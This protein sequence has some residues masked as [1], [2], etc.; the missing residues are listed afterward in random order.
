MYAPTPVLN[1]NLFIRLCKMQEQPAVGKKFTTHFRRMLIVPKNADQ[2]EVRCVP[3]TAFCVRDADVRR[4]PAAISPVFASLFRRL[5]WHRSAGSTEADGFEITR[6]GV[7]WAE[8]H[9]TR[10]FLPS[11]RAHRH[12]P[13]LPPGI[14]S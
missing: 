12:L 1:F 3:W 11:P 8:D 7:L 13:S 10:N 6:S 4:S 2:I 14:V 5:Q 9:W